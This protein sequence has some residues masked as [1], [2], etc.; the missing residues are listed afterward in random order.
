[1]FFLKQIFLTVKGKRDEK[2]CNY[3]E[4]YD[5]IMCQRSTALIPG[6]LRSMNAKD[7]TIEKLRARERKLVSAIVLLALL[8][9]LVLLV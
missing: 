5:P 8:L 1:M 9:L 6:L 2:G 4:W 7:A 3:F